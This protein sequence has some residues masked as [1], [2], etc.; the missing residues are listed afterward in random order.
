MLVTNLLGSHGFILLVHPAVSIHDWSVVMV[1]GDSSIAVTI[2]IEC[3]KLYRPVFGWTLILGP[4]IRDIE[5][6]S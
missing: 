3:N 6:P 5:V 2:R 1:G 4:S